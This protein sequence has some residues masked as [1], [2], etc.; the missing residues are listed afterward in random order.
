MISD[1]RLTILRMLEARQITANEA[2]GLLD[3]LEAPQPET[4]QPGGAEA[5][6]AEEEA[7]MLNALLQ[8]TETISSPAPT[9]DSLS[10]M[11]AGVARIVPVLAGVDHCTILLWDEAAQA[12]V[13]QAWYPDRRGSAPQ[14]PDAAL[15]ADVQNTG[16]PVPCPA[17]HC[18]VLPMSAQGSVC[19]VMQVEYASGPRDFSA[20]ETAILSNIACQAAVGVQSF[21]LRQEAF[22]HAHLDRELRLART[23]QTG[24]LPANAPTL[25]GWEI[26]SH[27][28]AAH[29]V[30]GDFYDFIPL[31]RHRLGVVLGDVSDKG[32][33]AALFMTMTRSIVRGS[34]RPSGRLCSGMERANRL[35]ASDARD[36]MF[37]T[38]FYA[39]LDEAASSL[40]Y[41]NAGHNPALLVS[42]AGTHL[43]EGRSMALGLDAHASMEQRSVNI[44][45]GDVL[46]MY[47]DGLTEATNKQMEQFGLD[48]LTI[49]VECSRALPA[50]GIVTQVVKAVQGFTG[51]EAVHD[52]A[53]IVVAKRIV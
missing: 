17:R 33:P 31:G 20:K 9:A 10:E 42:A 52:D 40:V 51:T 48:R 7:W 4:I 12:F 29:T 46:V 47:T 27:W 38:L 49:V 11:L 15:L 2:A 19:G 44:E 18:I 25:A 36:G 39:I 28:Q 32:M 26:A 30:G 23:V 53:A 35:I 13:P 8:V 24:L 6:T 14:L 41:T 22:E 45:P 43:L 3:A 5:V 16:Q 21:R 50:A 37:V 34:V 1:E